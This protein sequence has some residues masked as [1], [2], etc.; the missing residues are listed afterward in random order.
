MQLFARQSKF[1]FG[2]VPT[3][4]GQSQWRVEM[5]SIWRLVV[6][7]RQTQFRD[8]DFSF[9]DQ[10]FESKFLQFVELRTIFVGDGRNFLKS[11]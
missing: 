9:V 1:W 4:E 7:S 11:N 8:E 2:L 3:F 5:N 10:L 6:S